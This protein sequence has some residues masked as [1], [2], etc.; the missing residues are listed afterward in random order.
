M[1]I[2]INDMAEVRP[3][4]AIRPSRDKAHLLASRSYL[5]YSEE[6]LKEKLENNPFTFLHII[7]PDFNSKGK[8]NGDI[9]FNHIRDKYLEFIEKGYLIQD[10]SDYFYLYQQTKGK[11]NFEGIIAASSVEDYCNGTIKVHE[12]TLEKREKMFKEYLDATGFNSDPVLLAYESNKKINDIIAKNK[13][14]RPEYEFTT[15]DKVLHKLWIIDNESVNSIISEFKKINKIYIADG[16]HRTSSSALLSKEKKFNKNHN[17]NFFM[18]L[19][20]S[21]EQLKIDS[22]YRL[23]EDLNGLTVDDFLEEIRKK[24]EIKDKQ[25]CESCKKNEIGMYIDGKSYILKARNESYSTDCI[26]KLDCSILSKN[27]LSSILGIKNERIDNR[28]SFVAGKISIKEIKR[29][30]DKKKYAVA[31]ILNPIAIEDIKE[32]ADEQK[33]M[34]PKS[35]YIEPKLRSGLTIYPIE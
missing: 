22:F 29:S 17:G 8:K 12:H 21:E 3:F 28:L 16:H 25:N 30:V 6:T 2:L 32:V 5:T 23:V 26:S 33:V 13:K 24:F 4:T 31:F 35:T 14:A 18:S 10:K 34:P 7:N 1:N 27:I 9:K 19:L 11:D 20:I 15:T